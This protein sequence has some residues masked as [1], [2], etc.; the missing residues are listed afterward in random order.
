[1]KSKGPEAFKERWQ[2]IAD[3]SLKQCGRLDRLEI[4]IP[5]QLESLLL[6]KISEKQHY[7]HS[8]RLWCDEAGIDNSP[9][10]SDSLTNHFRSISTTSQSS[11]HILVGPEGGWSSQERLLL[12]REVKM[13]SQTSTNSIHSNFQV[14]LGKQIMRAE[15]AA[16]FTVSVVSAGFQSMEN[17]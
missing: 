12:D 15:T 1:M 6:R 11:V 16:L 5:I 9:F 10:I 17:K 14:H 7:P 8:I 13:T 3:Q 2:K 4:E